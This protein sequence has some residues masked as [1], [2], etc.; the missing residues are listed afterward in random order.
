MSSRTEPA[1][2]TGVPA[3][4][5]AG[6]AD[7]SDDV[8]APAPLARPQRSFAFPVQVKRFLSG[9]RFAV[10]ATVNPDGSPHQAVVWYRLD[11]GSISINS[12]EGR[13]WPSN[14][15]R[16]PRIS[17][18]VEDGYEWVS[19]RGTVEV[20]DE[21]QTAQADIAEMAY[22]YHDDRTEA[23][24]LIRDRFRKQRRVSFRIMPTSVSADLDE[25]EG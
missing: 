7:D 5:D 22:R 16:D 10:I 23:E 6:A 4:P 21:Q 14:L 20:I 3:D 24:A 18:F 11:D 13:R 9:A 12:L 19:V 15:R 17:F 1:P 8:P 25:E 2:P